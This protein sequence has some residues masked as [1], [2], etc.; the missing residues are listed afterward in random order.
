[1][2]KLQRASTVILDSATPSDG[3]TRPVE[4]LSDM[5]SRQRRIARQHDLA[6]KLLAQQ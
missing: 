1:M 3:V 2:S 6:S 4:N 5:L